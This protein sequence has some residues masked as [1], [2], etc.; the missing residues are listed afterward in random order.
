MHPQDRTSQNLI[1][2]GW[3]AALA[4]ANQSPRCGASTR[5]STPCKSPAMANGR[6]RMHGGKSTGAPKGNQN[7]FKHGMYI[8]EMIKERQ[9]FRELVREC[10]AVLSARLT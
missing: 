3:E 9:S 2:A 5:Q 6:C 1:F 7:A 8:A 10:S 4:L